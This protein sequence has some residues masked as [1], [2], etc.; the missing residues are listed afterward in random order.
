MGINRNTRIC[1]YN[2]D[3]FRIGWEFSNLSCHWKARINHNI[4]ECQDN[5]VFTDQVNGPNIKI[6]YTFSENHRTSFWTNFRKKLRQVIIPSDAWFLF[7]W[8]CLKLDTEKMW[9]QWFCLTMFIMHFQVF[10]FPGLVKKYKEL[11]CTK[12][13]TYKIW[14]FLREAQVFNAWLKKK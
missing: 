13:F 12:C 10:M 3:R 1:K 5:K 7:V 14:T 11:K 8:F 4:L 2:I 9:N 6:V